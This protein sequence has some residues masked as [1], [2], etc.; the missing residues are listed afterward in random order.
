MKLAAKTIC[1]V[2]TIK[3]IQITLGFRGREAE[4]NTY[5]PCR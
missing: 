5:G 1:N 2:N 4:V 3:F